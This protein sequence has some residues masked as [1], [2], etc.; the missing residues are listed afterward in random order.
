MG[1]EST[2]MIQE[3]GFGVRVEVE[4]AFGA[5][6]RTMQGA[7]VAPVMKIS[8]MVLCICEDGDTRPACVPEEATVSARH[9]RYDVSQKLSRP[10]ELQR[11]C[12]AVS[13]S[14]RV[15]APPQCG[16]S[17]RQRDVG[18]DADCAAKCNC[19]SGFSNSRQRG[20]KAPRRRFA[21]KP[22]KRMRTNPRG[23]VW[24]RNRRR[25]SSAVSVISRCWLW[26][27]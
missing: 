14:I 12:W 6:L 4:V 26:W 24:S 13:F 22:Q 25:N 2:L 1:I 15:M 21:R 11:S 23:R 19:G 18:V 20:N 5:A 7:P 17:Q 8:G 27:A 3:W 10:M 9:T 16:H